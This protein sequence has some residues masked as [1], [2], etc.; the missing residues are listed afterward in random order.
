MPDR[1]L[2]DNRDFI[3]EPGEWRTFLDREPP[4]PDGFRKHF[5]TG[6]PL[7]SA[8]FLR[9]MERLTGRVLQAQ[10]PGRKV[11]AGK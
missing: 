2:A 9:Q 4:M 8:E 10:P 7:G 11:R 5:R 6:R 1:L 3:E